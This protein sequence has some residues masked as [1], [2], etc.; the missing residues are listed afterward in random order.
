MENYRDWIQI[1][2]EIKN[3]ILEKI[4]TNLNATKKGTEVYKI[5]FTG[6]FSSKVTLSFVPSNSIAVVFF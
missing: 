6:T 1:K 3:S 4:L 5:G 2:E